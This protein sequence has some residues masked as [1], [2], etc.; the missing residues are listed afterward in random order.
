MQPSLNIIL[1]HL[2]NAPR[3]PVPISSPFP[4]SPIP[5]SFRQ[6]LFLCRFLSLSLCVCVCVCVCVC[7]KDWDV[8]DVEHYIGVRWTIWWFDF[9]M[10][11][12]G[13]SDGKESTCNAG[14][15]GLIPGLGRSPGGGQATHSSIL[16]W[17]IPWT[18]EPGRLQSLVLQ[19]VGHDWATK[20][21]T[22]VS[23]LPLTFTEVGLTNENCIHLRYMYT[24]WNDYCNQAN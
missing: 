18:E 11:F 13:G 19:R 2:N 1:K 17:R 6:S 14:D 7:F 16:A 22:F 3:N 12:P 20:H 21:C 10:G 23:I 15:L 4:F 8:I 9:C 24:Q 5:L